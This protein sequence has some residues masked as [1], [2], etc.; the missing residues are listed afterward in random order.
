MIDPAEIPAGA[1]LYLRPEQLVDSPVGRD[2]EVARIAGG[3]VWCAAYELI[4]VEDGRRVVQASLP[5]SRLPGMIANLPPAQA[6]RL[7]ELAHRISAPRA[8][9]TL[10]ERVLR[11]EQPQVMGILNVTPDSFS[12]GGKHQG[13]PG[14]IA[15]AG[16]DLGVAGAAV[17]DIGGESTRPGAATVWEG[18][19]IA[20]VV[21]VIAAMTP[22][23]TPISIDT[24]K[25]AVMEAA[26]AAGAHMVNDV[27]A[28]LWDDRAAGVVARAGCPVVLMHSPDPAKGPHGD[29]GYRDVLIEVFDWLE[30]RIEAVVAAGIDRAK[31]LIDPGIGFGKSLA[32]NLA[33]LNGLGLLHGLGVPIVLGASRKRMIG[34]LSHEAPVDE[35]LGGSL[36][37]ALHGAQQGAQILRVHDV[38]ETAQALRVWRGLRDA[39]LSAVR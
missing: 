5:V 18:D 14:A 38:A 32:D 22:G 37:L 24:R 25:A 8:P 26:L 39:A 4:A 36:A 31:I 16:F 7:R 12:D 21:P 30:A 10:G 13:D 23:G 19:E 15:R 27:A 34:A 2:G 20:R 29:E 3:L 11:F 9:M 1:R 28:L 33:L 35:R 6:E 17:V